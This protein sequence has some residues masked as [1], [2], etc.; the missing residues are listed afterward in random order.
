MPDPSTLA[1]YRELIP[2]APERIL[3]MA[4]ATTSKAADTDALLAKA[5]AE[6]SNQGLNLAFMITLI[7]LIASIVFFALGNEVAGVAM[8]SLPVVMLVRSFITR[9]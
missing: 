4:E 7:A 9:S 2:D 1:A 8:V 5:D 6:L 3:R